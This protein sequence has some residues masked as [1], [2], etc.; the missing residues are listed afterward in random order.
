MRVFVNNLTPEHPDPEDEKYWNFMAE[1]L[2]KRR[3]ADD[4]RP[5]SI[6]VTMTTQQGSLKRK[7]RVASFLALHGGKDPV[8]EIHCDEAQAEILEEW[9]E[10]MGAVIQQIPKEFHSKEKQ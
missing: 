4:T 10:M 5:V 6:D 2:N 7:A 1:S 8:L 9:L 3:Y